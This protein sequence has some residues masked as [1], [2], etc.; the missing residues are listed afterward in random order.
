M[1]IGK[2]IRRVKVVPREIDAPPKQ[3]PQEAP[4]EQEPEKEPVP[5]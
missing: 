5:A 1:E 4:K 3:A 2:E